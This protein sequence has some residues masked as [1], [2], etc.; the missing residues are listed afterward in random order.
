MPFGPSQSCH[1]IA[2]G[3]IHRFICDVIHSIHVQHAAVPGGMY[4][5]QWQPVVHL[6]MHV[7]M[8]QPDHLRCSY[9]QPFASVEVALSMISG[10]WQE[11]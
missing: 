9:K 6:K 1:T 2:L 8:T 11:Y 7:L 4:S 3:S 10:V 5:Q